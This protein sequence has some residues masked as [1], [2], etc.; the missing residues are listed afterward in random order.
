MIWGSSSLAV[1]EGFTSES[2]SSGNNKP[3]TLYFHNDRIISVLEPKGMKIPELDQSRTKRRT[4]SRLNMVESSNDP[5]FLLTMV[6]ELEMEEITPEIVARMENVE[7]ALVKF[8]EAKGA[9]LLE[10]GKEEESIFKP[11]PP[12]IA[13]PDELLGNEGN[14][15]FQSWGEHGYNSAQGVNTSERLQ[16]RLLEEA[17]E[18]I[19]ARLNEEYFIVEHQ[20]AFQQ[21]SEEEEILR[22]AQ[23]ALQKSREAAMLRKAQA[24]RRSVSAAKV[25][26]VYRQQEQQ[27][28]KEQYMEQEQQNRYEDLSFESKESNEPENPNK[29]SLGFDVPRK[30]PT[31]QVGSLSGKGSEGRD[32]KAMDGSDDKSDEDFW[33]ERRSRA[34]DGIPIL[35]NWIQD[36]VGCITGNVKKSIYFSDGATIS[37]SSV[38]N[39][40]REGTLVTTESGSQ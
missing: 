33:E 9:A 22:Q 35:Y 34:P 21:Y 30:R 37:T 15:E 16:R 10:E 40:A 8:L 3:A 39:R 25:S 13:P 6:E 12:S 36:E 5:A 24:E 1:L 2:I 18:R 29:N 7:I 23:E 4:T 14:V 32:D 27:R 20:Q 19:R 26:A 17:L 11:F 28:K 38:T 31:I